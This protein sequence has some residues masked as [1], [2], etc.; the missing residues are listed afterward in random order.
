MRF[1]I[2][3]LCVLLTAAPVFAQTYPNASFGASIAVSGKIAVIGAPGTADP[4]STS[5]AVGGVFIF[6]FGG[7]PAAWRQVN[8]WLPSNEDPY[9]SF[10]TSVATNGGLVAL[11][12]SVDN[13]LAIGCGSVYLL[14][15]SG[16]T[17]SPVGSKVVPTL[18]PNEDAR[19]AH[20]GCCLA[21]SSDQLFVGAEYSDETSTGLGASACDS[22]SVFVFT[23]S[24]T[25]GAT[26][27]ARLIGGDT[28]C[29]DHFGHA[30]AVSKGL[31]VV[32][33]PLAGASP[34]LAGRVYLFSQQPDE[35]WEA[36]GSISS[37]V[38][39]EREQFGYAVAAQPTGTGGWYIAVGAPTDISGD[40]GRVY[41][42]DY[43]P[44][45]LPAPRATLTAQD[46]QNRDMF[47]SSIAMDGSSILIGARE[48][49]PDSDPVT[50]SGRGAAYVANMPSPTTLTS[51]LPVSDAPQQLFGIS[52]AVS[53]NGLLV[54]G[55]NIQNVNM[56]YSGV[57]SVFNRATFQRTDI[58]P[59]N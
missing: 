5:S 37:P 25:S 28:S 51:L 56:T 13:S 33:A 53:P 42:F 17:W 24:S 48:R 16:N 31:M 12:S 38:P 58:F 23:A 1:G 43:T 44:G 52:V 40:R 27:V 18:L 22:G 47:G 35:S 4:V 2:R 8:K 9:D 3:A 49:K 59:L 45:T 55:P 39:T 15:P 54:G 10:G 26:Q 41:L 20:F 29:G 32:G 21:M 34:R 30:I 6:T 11:G 19:N 7:T 50:N 57:V 36:A 14:A 46:A